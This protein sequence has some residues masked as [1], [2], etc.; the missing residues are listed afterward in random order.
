MTER[1]FLAG[2]WYQIPSAWSAVTVRGMVFCRQ[3]GRYDV[4]RWVRVL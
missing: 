1:F 2:E 4:S 3:F